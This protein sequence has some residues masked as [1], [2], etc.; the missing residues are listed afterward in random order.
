VL[1]LLFQRGLRHS[2]GPDLARTDLSGEAIRC[3]GRAGGL[4]TTRGDRPPR[5]MLLTT[6]PA[7]P[8]R[9]RRR[10]DPLAEQDRSRWDRALIAEGVALITAALRHVGWGSIRSR[11]HR[12]RPRPGA[13]ARRHNWSEIVALYGRLE[14]MTGNPMV[15]L[16]RAVAVA[17]AD[18]RPPACAARGARG[19]IGDHHRLHASAPPAGALR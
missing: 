9:P 14:Q 17:M 2:S 7:R 13:G 4:P 19:P 12:R 11:R 15:T 3:P 10:P 1:Y 5:L 8:H 16:N 6:P 18:G